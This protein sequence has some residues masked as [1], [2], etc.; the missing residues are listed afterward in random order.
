MIMVYPVADQSSPPK[1]DM[2]LAGKYG[3]LGQKKLRGTTETELG[4]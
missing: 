2:Y 3:N 1:Y 4:L